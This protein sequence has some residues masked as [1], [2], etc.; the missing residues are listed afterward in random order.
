M[1]EEEGS[2][3]RWLMPVISPTWEVEIRRVALQDQPG[4]KVGKT[5]SQSAG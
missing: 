4:E 2:Q 1:Q 5:S 3:A